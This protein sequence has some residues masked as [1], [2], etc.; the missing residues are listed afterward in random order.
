M[1]RIVT[2]L[3]LIA[4]ATA[5]ESSCMGR[6]GRFAKSCWNNKKIKAAILSTAGL[7]PLAYNTYLSHQDDLYGAEK[8]QREKNQK[9]HD[10]LMRLAPWDLATQIANAKVMGASVATLKHLEDAQKMF[11]EIATKSKLTG[12][13]WHFAPGITNCCSPSNKTIFIEDN[14]DVQAKYSEK[15]QV[16]ETTKASALHEIGHCKSPTL[17]L[18]LRQNQADKARIAGIVYLISCFACPPARLVGS[19]L[20]AGTALLASK[21]GFFAWGRGEELRADSYANQYLLKNFKEGNTQSLDELKKRALEF[22]VHAKTEADLVAKNRPVN[23]T[24]SQWGN[25]IKNE[26][27]AKKSLPAVFFGACKR[28]WENVSINYLPEAITHYKLQAKNNPMHSSSL[29]RSKTVEHY[30]AQCK[31]HK[32]T[33]GKNS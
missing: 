2:L 27:R 14:G 15:S 7:I 16:P 32:Q 19:F 26:I 13:K 12:I 9:L 23:M 8:L 1:K 24:V 17:Q 6:F 22:V 11:D 33:T 28:L 20:R 25:S 29:K 10:E 31:N 3:A 30:I 4:L 18:F 21:I 5:G